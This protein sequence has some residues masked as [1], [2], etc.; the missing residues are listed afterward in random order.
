MR[1]ASAA[2]IRCERTQLIQQINTVLSA[3]LPAASAPQP[4]QFARTDIGAQ[5]LA[6]LSERLRANLI[7]ARHAR[8]SLDD[9]FRH[10]IAPREA[11]MLVIEAAPG[12]L[13][14]D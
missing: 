14:D 9:A 6:G 5:I 13:E 11:A 7:V 2:R 1:V 12:V 8:S 3:M 10:T 4:T